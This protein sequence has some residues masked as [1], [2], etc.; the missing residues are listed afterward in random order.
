MDLQQ[1]IQEPLTPNKKNNTGGETNDRM[2]CTTCRLNFLIC[3]GLLIHGW[4][5]QGISMSTEMIKRKKGPL[6]CT[7]TTTH[8]NSSEFDSEKL[9]GPH[10]DPPSPKA[11]VDTYNKDTT[12][13]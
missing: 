6:L 3:L 2:V 9:N 5:S 11:I 4:K 8:Y 10:S 1:R 7:T 12:H 13:Q